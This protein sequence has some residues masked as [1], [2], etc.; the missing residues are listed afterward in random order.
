MKDRARRVMRLWRKGLPEETASA[1][2]VGRTASTHCRPCSCWMCA[3]RPD[4]TPMR[5]RRFE[6]TESL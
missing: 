2:E 6:N 4:I 5:E 1:R 3:G